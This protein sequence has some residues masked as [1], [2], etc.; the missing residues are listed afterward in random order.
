LKDNAKT[1]YVSYYKMRQFMDCFGT[2]KDNEALRNVQQLFREP[3]FYGYLSSTEASLLLSYE[4]PP[5]TFL[6]RFRQGLGQGN[7]FVI[8]V[9]NG[10]G[11][12]PHYPIQRDEQGRFVVFYDG[13]EIVGTSVFEMVA[14]FQQLGVL[15]QGLDHPCVG[16]S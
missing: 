12:T 16:K 7:T 11:D 1:G 14:N 4:T 2:L 15:K 6:V 10:G 5:G 13:N 9:T 3:Y 8:S